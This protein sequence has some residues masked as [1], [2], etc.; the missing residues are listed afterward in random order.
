[1]NDVIL[2]FGVINTSFGMCVYYYKIIRVPLVNEGQLLLSYFF[3]HGINIYLKSKTEIKRFFVVNFLMGSFIKN[4]RT[5]GA[6]DK[7]RGRFLVKSVKVCVLRLKNSSR[8]VIFT[9]YVYFLLKRTIDK[10]LF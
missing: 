7:E 1:M 9:K 5:F 6:S 10:N 3:S 4:Y 2:V 8:T